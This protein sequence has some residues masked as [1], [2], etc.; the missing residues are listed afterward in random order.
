MGGGGKRGKGA[1]TGKNAGALFGEGREGAEEGGEWRRG[2]GG[3]SQ[4]AT[5]QC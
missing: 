2:H 5:W 3:A 4:R 1:G